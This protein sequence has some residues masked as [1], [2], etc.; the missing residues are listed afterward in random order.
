MRRNVI[1]E[2]VKVSQLDVWRCC[3]CGRI[4]AKH[5]VSLSPG[6]AVT[7]EVKC[8]CNQMNTLIVAIPAVPPVLHVGHN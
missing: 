3:G 8:A 7:F 4:L 5:R 6:S 2:K 1:A